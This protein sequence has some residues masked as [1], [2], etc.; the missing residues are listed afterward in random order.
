MYTH[1]HLYI[2]VNIYI[3]IHTHTHTVNY[4]KENIPFA[5]YISEH[6]GN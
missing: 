1:T 6:I 4:S 3:C 2:Y 5:I